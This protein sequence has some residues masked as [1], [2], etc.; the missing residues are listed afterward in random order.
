[1]AIDLQTQIKRIDQICLLIEYGNEYMEELKGH[2]PVLNQNIC[3]I[4]EH[5]RNPESCFNINEEFVIQV[6]KDIIYGIEH[7]DEVILLDVLRHGLMVIYDYAAEV[8][9]GED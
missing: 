3:D 5:A 6:L 9:C 4:L 2:L 8:L 1:M 7:T